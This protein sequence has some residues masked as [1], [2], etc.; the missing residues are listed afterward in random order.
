MKPSLVQKPDLE[1][2]QYLTLVIG[3]SCR[4]LLGFIYMWAHIFSFIMATK[5]A[6]GCVQVLPGISGPFEIFLISYWENG[7]DMMKFVGSRPHVR[8]MLFIYKYPRSLNLFNETY[9]KPQAANYINRAKGYAACV[10][11]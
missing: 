1:N 3:L 2:A 7:Q 5:R 4:N 11:K 6:S 9:S 8:W 10:V